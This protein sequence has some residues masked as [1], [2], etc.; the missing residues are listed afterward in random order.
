L[1]R[2]LSLRPTVPEECAD[3]CAIAREE[4]AT[5]LDVA[6][7]SA[8]HSVPFLTIKDIANNEF[9]AVTDSTGGFTN[10]PKAEAGRRAAALM[11]RLIERLAASSL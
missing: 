6:R 7:V 1:R 9:H 3:A 4:G 2:N 10:V 8:L 5:A 11:L